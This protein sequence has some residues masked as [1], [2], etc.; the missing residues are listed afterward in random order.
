LKGYS[1]FKLKDYNTA[2]KCYN[3]ALEANNKVE[4]KIESSKL[5]NAIG[6]LYME[7]NE[8]KQALTYFTK[9][10]KIQELENDKIVLAQSLNNLGCVYREL[11]DY[12]KAKDHFTQ[13][14][15][16]SQ[17]L[18]LNLTKIDN[19]QSLYELY[20]VQNESKT[21]L[22]YYQKYVQL[23]D[24][25]FKNNPNIEI[26]PSSETLQNEKLRL[27][28]QLVF[29][30]KIMKTIAGG[31]IGIIVILLFIIFR[32]RSQSEKSQK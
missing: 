28:K 32:L 2:L 7:L 25:V 19:Y 12:K 8:Y 9:A 1:L 20:F 3:N 22:E 10:Y 30:T 5:N 13:S 18:G 27:K 24:S 11:G 6:Q 29:N 23:R 15:T 17:E 26:N 21:A 31:A 14:L 4:N 16:I